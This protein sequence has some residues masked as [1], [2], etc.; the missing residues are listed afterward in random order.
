MKKEFARIAAVVGLA[1]CFDSAYAQEITV[2]DLK[3][4]GAVLLSAEELKAFLPGATARFETAEYAYQ[5]KLEAG[6]TTSGSFMKRLGG[7][8]M[9][10]FVGDWN[11]SDDGRWCGTQRSYRSNEVVL[12]YCRDVLKLGDAYYYAGGNKNN[13]QRPV[14]EMKVSR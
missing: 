7:R 4:K 5:M 12:K 2:A 11:L 10:Q 13:D 8:Q 14:T 9:V 6:G 1:L 3:S